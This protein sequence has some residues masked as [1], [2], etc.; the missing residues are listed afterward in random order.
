MKKFLAIVLAAVLLGVGYTYL[1]GDTQLLDSLKSAPQKGGELLQGAIA[2]VAPV[3]SEREVF[4]LIDQLKRLAMNGEMAAFQKLVLMDPGTEQSH[5][6]G[7]AGFNSAGYPGR[8]LQMVDLQ[9]GSYLIYASYFQV[10]G[11][12][13]NTQQRNNYVL[14][15]LT[16]S[17]GQWTLDVRHAELAKLLDAHLE[18]ILLSPDA[19]EAARAGRNAAFGLQLSRYAQKPSY[20]GHTQ[21][22][23]AEMWQNED[24]SLSVNFTVQ[25]GTTTALR[26]HT[27]KKLVIKRADGKTVLNLSNHKINETVSAGQNITFTITIP[28]NRLRNAEGL[29]MKEGWSSDHTLSNRNI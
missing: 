18:K 26:Y 21:V 23:L 9:D 3:P 28:K 10:S 16:K 11:R 24:G 25:N 8:A 20:P 4:D 6:K 22:D 17:G 19:K 27:I 13:P 15:L 12:H 1:S 5:I 14:S 7:M 2:A 29:W